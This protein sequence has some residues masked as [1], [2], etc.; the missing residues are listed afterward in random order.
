[1]TKLPALLV[2]SFLVGRSTVLIAAPPTLEKADVAS[3]V[4]HVGGPEAMFTFRVDPWSEGMHQIR[5]IGRASFEGTEP[6]DVFFEILGMYR[7]D[8]AHETRGV[9]LYRDA[10]T[11]ATVPWSGAYD[12]KQKSLQWNAAVGDRKLPLPAVRPFTPPAGGAAQAQGRAKAGDTAKPPV[13]G[14]F[15]KRPWQ[16]NTE[17]LSDKDGNLDFSKVIVELIDLSPDPSSPAPTKSNDKSK[18]KAESADN[19]SLPGLEDV[20]II[21]AITDMG[22]DKAKSGFFTPKDLLERALHGGPPPRKRRIYPS[23]DAPRVVK[24]LTKPVLPSSQSPTAPNP[25]APNVTAPN[26]TA[27]NNT[28]PNFVGMK[29]ENAV[30]EAWTVGLN[31]ASIDCLGPAKDPAQAERVVA[32]TPAAGSP[33]PTDRN[34]RLQWYAPMERPP[35]T[36]DGFQPTDGPKVDLRFVEAQIAANGRAIGKSIIQPKKEVVAWGIVL[37]D[38]PSL[39][40]NMQKTRDQVLK[41]MAETKGS[42]RVQIDVTIRRDTP[43][44]IAFEFSSHSTFNGEPID[45]THHHRFIE[46]RGF[47]ITYYHYRDGFHQPLAAMADT[48]IENSRRLIDLRFPK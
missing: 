42:D 12:V 48:A 7:P 23:L 6:A 16:S 20:S 46:Y 3:G 32:Q 22:A 30:N 9:L 1:M 45:S 15:A 33:F 36:P 43:G 31:P 41:L 44:D 26:L 14:L 24:T 37:I 19:D 18:E 38:E 10:Q 29:F 8:Q 39:R 2:V 21:Q 4:F 28:V 40:D 11:T 34:L 17:T 5:G 27:P 47:W 35:G 25:V 13:V